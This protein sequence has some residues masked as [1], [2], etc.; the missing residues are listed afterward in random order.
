MLRLE[1]FMEIQK[2]HHDG[3]SVSE[4]ARQLDMDR[5]TVRKYLKQAPREYERK[6]KSWQI[7]PYRAYLRE[8]W[9]LGVHNAAKLFG[10]LR[11]RGYGGCLTQVKKVV[12]PWRS[13]GQERA[14][15][16]FET[17]PG[18]QAQMDWGHFG[19]WN[20]KRLYGFALTLCW[21][22]MRY[23]EFTQRQDAETLL[24]CMVHAFEFF[25]GVTQTVLT[26]NMKTVVVD[27]IDGQ[28]RFHAKM[29]DFASYY[30]FIPRVC[31]PYRPE[32]KGKIESTVRFIKGN[33]WPGIEFD[34]LKELNRQGLAWCGEVNGRV[35][36]TT[37]EI[38]QTRFPQEGLT[39]L[40]GQPAY[41]TSYV[42][43]RQ[44]AKDCLFSY[45]GNRYSVPHAYAGKSVLVRE[46][47]DSGTIRVFDQQ[48]LIA[49]HK[50]AT[51]KG[52]MVV[53]AAHY[54]ELPRR[55]SA[56]AVKP[57][58]QAVAELSPGP[59]VGLHYPVPEV[60]FRPL[61][62]YNAFC[63]EVAHVASV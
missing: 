47:L 50:T 51:G 25:G 7:D 39:P 11:K 17:A 52:A 37:R 49:Q 36:S 26:D 13:E 62:I 48:N 61:S 57:P 18:E 28:P 2:L 32:T 31:R 14:F 46:P 5:K 60:E 53:E 9:E 1:D 45:R 29:L 10:E 34:S 6:P 33:F 3:V 44:V 23:V 41:D 19:N 21:S 4:I 56:S 27:R 63:E 59:G 16:R 8:R 38:P 22:R 54:A 43:H 40:N 15:V 20:G 24:N 55:S 35:H 12:R 42:S 30:G 58:L